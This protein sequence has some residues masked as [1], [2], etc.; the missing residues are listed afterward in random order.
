[1]VSS[2]KYKF[3]A[4]VLIFII[5]SCIAFSFPQ[6]ELDKTDYTGGN[7]TFEVKSSSGTQVELYINSKLIETK[8]SISPQKDFLLESTIENIELGVSQSLKFTNNNP[9]RSYGINITDGPYALLDY[10]ESLIFSAD[11]I[12]SITYKDEETS[13]SKTITITDILT[14]I[15]F[16]NL[17]NKLNDGD[18]S[19]KFIQKYPLS[20]KANDKEYEYTIR[21]D[22]SVNTIT[23]ENI[24][25]TTNQ[26]EVYV[27]GFVSDASYPLYYIVN[28]PGEILNLGLLNPITKDGNKFN[29]RI[30]GLDE[31]ENSIRFISTDSQNPR[32]FNGEITKRVFIDTIAP[33]IIIEKAYFETKGSTINL[34]GKDIEEGIYINSNSLKMLISVDAKELTIEFND[35]SEKKEVINNSIEISLSLKEGKNNLTLI[36]T[37]DAGNIG[38]VAHEIHFS[39]KKPDI[40]IDTMEPK[41]LFTGSKT[42]HSFIEMINGETNKPHVD[43]TIFTLPRDAKYYDKDGTEKRVTCNDYESVFSRTAS[44]I[45]QGNNNNDSNDDD[46]ENIRLNL[47]SL[48]F[49]KQEVTSDS[50]NK[51]KAIIGLQEEDPNDNKINTDYDEFDRERTSNEEIGRVDSTNYICFVM[52]DRYG[53]YNVRSYTVELDAGNTMWKPGEITTIPNTMYASEIENTGDERL[54]VGRA[55]FSVIA[56]FDYVGPGKVSKIE[57]A[58]FRVSMDNAIS[59]FSKYGDVITSEMNYAL[60]TET[61]RATIY[62]PVEIKPLNKDPIDY[63]DNIRFGFQ[64]YV[65]Y[66]VD[67]KDIPIDTKNPIYFQ[68]TINIEKPLDHAKWLSPEML[69]NM[70]AFLNKTIA[71]TETAVKYTGYATIGGV[72]AC[73]GAKFWYGAQVAAANGDEELINNAREKMF[74]VCDRIACTA[75]PM[76]CADQAK[77]FETGGKANFDTADL[78]GKDGSRFVNEEDGE[79]VMGRVTDLTVTNTKC[80][81]GDGGPGIIVNADIEKYEKD[82][83]FG[84]NG[85]LAGETESKRYLPGQCVPVKYKGGV[86]PPGDTVKQQDIESIDLTAISGVC[87]NPEAPQFDKT[88]CNFFGADPEGNPGWDPS[89]N[90]FE[91]VRCGCITDTYSHLKN[92]LKIQQAI[93]GCLEQAK[94]GNTKGSYCERLLG[95]AVCDVATNLIFKTLTQESSRY[96]SDG[97]TDYHESGAVAAIQGAREGD[98]ILNDRYRGTFYTQAGLSTEQITNKMCLV[99]IT[100]DW[101]LLSENILSSI[102]QNEVEPVFGPIFPESRLQGYN[103]L[104]GALSIQYRF[105][106]ATVSGGQ[107]ITT[108]VNF[109]C[110]KNQPGGEHC[111]DGRINA[112][113]AGASFSVSTLYTPEDGSMQDTIVAYDTDA[114]FRYNVVQFEH[115][116]TLKGEQKITTREENIFHKGEFMLANCYFTGGLMTAGAGFSCDTLFDND[117]L[118][119]AYQLVDEQTHVSPKMS[120]REEVFYPGNPVFVTVGYDI[121]TDQSNSQTSFDLAYKAICK[122]PEG[123]DATKYG[124]VNVPTRGNNFGIETVMLIPGNEMTLGEVTETGSV[125]YKLKLTKDEV[126]DYKNGYLFFKN[127]DAVNSLGF[128]VN[129]K[130]NFNLEGNAFNVPQD[131]SINGGGSPNSYSVTGIDINGDET[132][133]V[134]EIEGNLGNRLSIKLGKTS[135]YNSADK[136]FSSTSRNV[137]DDGSF[138]ALQEGPCDLY[139]RIFPQGGAS[140]ITMDNFEDYDPTDAEQTGVHTNVDNTEMLKRDFVFKK[141]PAT[142]EEGIRFE[143]VT[144]KERESIC[145]DGTF[146]PEYVFLTADGSS[147]G[148]KIDFTVSAK[149]YTSAEGKGEDV[150]LRET[151]GSIGTLSTNIAPTD[152]LKQDSSVEMLMTYKVMNK[153]GVDI[154]GAEGSINFYGVFR[155]SCSY[156]SQATQPTTPNSDNDEDE[157][158]DI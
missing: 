11:E 46:K 52:E 76:E 25:N 9:S 85:W 96:A 1:M 23:I 78:E 157:N 82:Y 114:R 93:K 32:I 121:K 136:T 70:V 127:N 13:D 66:S 119:S 146:T 125:E 151:K 142:A 88:R 59:E 107:R 156:G 10:G 137:E 83:T 105:T 109:I 38:K 20:T 124:V 15:N 81:A 132:E 135:D 16:N 69:D 113:D 47:L 22:K 26:R 87:F 154:K 73:T 99:A 53:N 103:P 19:V 98:K 129:G 5:L 40:V 60:D 54:N 138:N 106:Y 97:S 153:E 36:A 29:L 48:V 112:K 91:S 133:L 86:E 12:G 120:G 72:I 152:T 8:D 55:R 111:P 64:A 140:G 100:G 147:G 117:A 24:T 14:T 144:P 128:K 79:Q 80:Q 71:Y 134:I 51:F 108:K 155:D 110:D 18:N 6:L 37:D 149:R 45:N 7:I 68:T 116:Y 145:I 84:N 27:Q 102:E 141:T 148:A 50:D 31:G 74:M 130:R 92:Y 126:N 42:S 33:E 4:I 43:M 28:Y 63:P 94:I 67:D 139:L 49:Q 143:L 115:H 150:D 34:T 118:L 17:E 158:N 21:Y 123:T 35:N 95:Q 77:Q 41:E 89:D 44:Q 61:G 75:S 104:T 90:I 131:L 58:G 30:I 65:S 57:R 62:F 56:I 39:N 3:F 101:S 2:T 122:G